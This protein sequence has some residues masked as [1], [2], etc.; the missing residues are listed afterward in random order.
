MG[1][2]AHSRFFTTG[3]DQSV[4]GWKAQWFR[5]SWLQPFACEAGLADPPGSGAPAELHDLKS[6][7][8]PAGSL[9]VGGI[10]IFS[11][12]PIALRSLP[13]SICTTASIPATLL[14][15]RPAIFCFS[16]WHSAHWLV[17]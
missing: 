4:T 2:V 12:Y 11:S 15:S 3:G 13:C 1:D 6:P 14:K 5:F 7:M 10:R 8:T 16:L 9:P 17:N